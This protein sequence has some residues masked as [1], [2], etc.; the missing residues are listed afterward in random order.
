MAGA[1]L[2]AEAVAAIV[3]LLVVATEPDAVPL[4]EPLVAP[5]P[6]SSLPLRPAITE[7]IT[8]NRSH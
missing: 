2:T 8:A 3:A 1:D 5:Q 7:F 6:V 4:V